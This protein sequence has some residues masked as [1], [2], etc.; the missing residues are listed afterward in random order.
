MLTVA[1]WSRTDLLSC[2]HSQL[3]NLPVYV[4]VSAVWAVYY[5]SCALLSVMLLGCWL[6]VQSP[7][8]RDFSLTQRSFFAVTLSGITE[9]KVPTELPSG[10]STIQ[11]PPTEWEEVLYC[12]CLSGSLAGGHLSGSCQCSQYWV[13]MCARVL[14]LLDRSWFQSPPCSGWPSLLQI[15]N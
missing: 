11:R 1:V 12:V 4:P 13:E 8:R 14:L 2:L 5:R 6:S 15:Y 9:G 10:C 7:Q 3:P